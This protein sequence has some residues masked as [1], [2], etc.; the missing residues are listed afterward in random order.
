MNLKTRT[1]SKA[2]AIKEDNSPYPEP[3]DP[4]A[5]IDPDDEY[6]TKLVDALKDH[7]QPQS[8]GDLRRIYNFQPMESAG[9]DRQT[10]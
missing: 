9:G 3:I 10:S 7:E 4:D 8:L 6:L 5:N 2:A 1:K